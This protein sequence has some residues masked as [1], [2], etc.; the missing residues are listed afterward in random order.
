MVTINIGRKETIFFV[1]VLVVVLVASFAISY[2]TGNPATF[3]HSAGEVDITLPNGSVVNLQTAVSNQWIGDGVGGGSDGV[4]LNVVLGGFISNSKVDIGTN[5]KYVSIK[6]YGDDDM[7][8]TTPVG[9]DVWKNS[10]GG[11]NAVMFFHDDGN[12]DCNSEYT[13]STTSQGCQSLY[14]Y[15]NIS[16]GGLI[17]ESSSGDLGFDYIVF[18]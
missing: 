17:L 10:T 14:I 13:I 3:G 8:W 11:K 5:W 18:N 16:S 6:G 9:G 4:G 12:D 1:G 7:Q 15:E 2:G